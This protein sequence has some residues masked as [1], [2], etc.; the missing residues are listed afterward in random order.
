MK[1]YLITL[2]NLIAC[3]SAFADITF[4]N[5][6]S[7]NIIVYY[8]YCHISHEVPYDHICQSENSLTINGNDN[9]N[10]HFLT[11]PHPEN[12]EES[13]QIERAEER[14][15]HDGQLIA[16]AV[17]SKRIRN[18]SSCGYPLYNVDGY[19]P[20]NKD[21]NNIAIIFDDKST[22]FLICNGNSY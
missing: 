6:T 17:Y 16:S 20:E 5:Q 1:K 22:P 4:I 18:S 2:I 7:N 19:N 8:S 10:K 15:N 9:K 13:I 14:S 12:N 3:S 21:K 11:I